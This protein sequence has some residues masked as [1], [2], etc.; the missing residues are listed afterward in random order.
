MLCMTSKTTKPA[1]GARDQPLWIWTMKR[2]SIWRGTKP[3]GTTRKANHNKHNTA[4]GRGSKCHFLIVL[5][6]AGRRIPCLQA[7]RTHV[8]IRRFSTEIQHYRSLLCHAPWP[9]ILISDPITVVTKN[10]QYNTIQQQQQQQQEALSAF[11]RQPVSDKPAN[12]PTAVPWAEPR[13]V[14]QLR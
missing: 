7:P 10:T 12:K 2:F 14:G 5:T 9:L 11:L 4:G 1:E 6:W 3:H 13:C 8:A